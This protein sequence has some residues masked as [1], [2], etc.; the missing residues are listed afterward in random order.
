M[1]QDEDCIRDVITNTFCSGKDTQVNVNLTSQKQKDDKRTLAKSIYHFSQTMK[2][3]CASFIS[4][5]R[6]R[7]MRRLSLTRLNADPNK[8]ITD[9]T[10]MDFL[11]FMDLFGAFSLR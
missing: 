6:P 4:G 10:I 2:D 9:S 1:K 11:D 7:N 5:Y 3:L 8:P